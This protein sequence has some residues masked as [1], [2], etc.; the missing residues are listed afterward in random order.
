VGVELPDRACGTG[1]VARGTVEPL[2]PRL[3]CPLPAHLLALLA[4]ALGDGAGGIVSGRRAARTGLR[5]G[6]TVAV[7]DRLTGND[8]PAATRGAT[9]RG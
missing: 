4:L 2:T 1:W 8:R 7:I 9:R 5:P 6:G 3:A